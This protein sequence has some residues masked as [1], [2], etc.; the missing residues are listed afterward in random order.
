M[1]ILKCSKRATLTLD[2]G[3]LDCHYQMQVKDGYIAEAMRGSKLTRIQES[4]RVLGDH[5]HPEHN[6][7]NSGNSSLALTQKGAPGCDHQI[8]LTPLIDNSYSLYAACSSNLG[9]VTVVNQ[10]QDEY[11]C[12][13]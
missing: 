8:F 13:M 4:F 3:E 6:G 9:N 1:T 12:V 11:G 7:F 10:A 2:V 5:F